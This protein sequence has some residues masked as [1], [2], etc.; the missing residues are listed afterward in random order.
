MDDVIKLLE[1]IRPGDDAV[2]LPGK[3][4]GCEWQVYIV[5]YNEY[6]N[7]GNGG[8][9]IQVVSK[10]EIIKMHEESGGNVCTFFELFP[11]CL[12]GDYRYCDRGS[13][14][15]IEYAKAYHEA[16]FVYG[17]DGGEVEEMEFLINFAKS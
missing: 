12:H 14:Q 9:D 13:P 1:N 11:N 8:F 4:H 6:S 10:D 15:F 2:F 16:D 17:R 5:Y 7:G 3:V